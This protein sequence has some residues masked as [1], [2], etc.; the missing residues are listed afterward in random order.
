[1]QVRQKRGQF[2]T[3]TR[4]LVLCAVFAALAYAVMI[5]FRFNVQ[6]LT[7]DLKDA[8]ITVAGLLLGPVA[9]LS[10]S[11]LVAVLEFVTVSDTGVYGL[12]M[13]MASSVTF[14]MVASAVY[15]YRKRLSGAVVGLASAALALVSVMLTLNLFVTPYYMGVSRSAVAEMI[16]T[17]L[18]PFNAVKAL[19]NASLVLVIYKPISRA[20]V[21]AGLLPRRVSDAP[22]E[23]TA[24]RKMH[25][26]LAVTLIGLA[27]FVAAVLSVFFALGGRP[28]WL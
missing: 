7:F 9:A 2:L 10:V 20:M 27:L 13:N 8:V 21:A 28:E 12:I 15:T 19:T 14:S 22:N 18:L 5:V 6:F 24:K 25:I 11:L 16:P 4:R 3:A 17:L 23:A 26:S 1:M